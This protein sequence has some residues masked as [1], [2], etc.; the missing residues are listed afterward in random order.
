MLII[1]LAYYY[2]IIIQNAFSRPVLKEHV[3]WIPQERSVTVKAVEQECG[4]L[5]AAVFPG[6]G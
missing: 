4:H 5:T 1:M 3:E 6:R 2:V